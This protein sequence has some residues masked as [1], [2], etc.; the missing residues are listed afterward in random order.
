[1][2][3]SG[4]L[5]SLR[6]RFRLIGRGSRDAPVAPLQLRF[7]GATTTAFDATPTPKG[8]T[9][10][11]NPRPALDIAGQNTAP[12]ELIGRVAGTVTINEVLLTLADS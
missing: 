6:G 5:A 7:A 10:E 1:L 4:G 11:L 12:L 2:P 9:I 3:N 8:A